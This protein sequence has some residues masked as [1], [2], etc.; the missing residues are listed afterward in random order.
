M[1]TEH[2]TH[3]HDEGAVLLE[4]LGSIA[5]ITWLVPPLSMH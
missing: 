4:Q 2:A 3:Q 5:T 1:S